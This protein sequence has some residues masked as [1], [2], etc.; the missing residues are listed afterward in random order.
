M[1]N[2]ESVVPEKHVG[3]ETGI[4][5]EVKLEMLAAGVN[6]GSNGLSAESELQEPKVREQDK[7][8]LE[9]QDNLLEEDVNIE[10]QKPLPVESPHS[11]AV[12]AADHLNGRPTADAS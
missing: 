5:T 11:R 7:E 4:V 3:K 1:G 9:K 2:V 12:V 6:G 8:N 10:I